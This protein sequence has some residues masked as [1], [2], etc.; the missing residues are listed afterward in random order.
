M[1]TQIDDGCEII[2][3]LK[4]KFHSN[5][6]RSQQVT[7]LTILPKGW[8]VQKVQEEF[9]VSNYMAHKAKELVK[10]Q[11]I[12]SSPNPKHGSGLPLTTVNL[13]KKF[14]EL[15]DISCIMPGKKDFVSVRQDGKWIHVQKR[16]LLSN[17]KELYQQFKEKHPMEK[18]GFSKFAELC[19]QY[20]ILAGASGTH[21]LCVCTIHHNV[22][23]MMIGGKITEQ[24]VEY[25][26]PLKE[27]S[28]C[29]ARIICNPPQPDCYFR[30]CSS[31]PGVSNLKEHLHE[32]MDSNL[33]EA[34]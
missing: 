12:L 7:I 1:P 23:L 21:A 34:V 17:L 26:V 30:I 9:R 28:H 22:K 13:I 31:Y 8:S 11:G 20:C 4:E 16:L 10:K 3:Q 33:V 6:D 24:S 18:I 32:F 15:D 29:L 14:Y 5:I 2:Q 19:P 25:D 27:Y